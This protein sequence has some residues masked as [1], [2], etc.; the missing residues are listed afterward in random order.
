MTFKNM[1]KQNFKLRQICCFILLILFLLPASSYAAGT[2]SGKVFEDGGTTPIANVMVNFFLQVCGGP[3]PDGAFQT[4]GSGNY[5]GSLPAGNY[6]VM[7]YAGGIASPYY[8]DEWYDGASGKTDCN[9]G[10]V[11]ITVTDSLTTPNIN[12]TLTRGGKITGSVFQSDGTT[13]IANVGA[14]AFAGSACGGSYIGG[15]AS[16]TYSMIVPP[17]TYY[18]NTSFISPQPFVNEWWD[19]SVSS[20][21]YDC[22]K[23]AAVQVT[24][25]NETSG[26]DFH[27]QNGVTI[28]GTVYESDG[29]TPIP[30]IGVTLYGDQCHQNHQMGTMADQNGNYTF[31]ALPGTYYVLCDASN[32]TFVPE[33]YDR[34]A[35]TTDCKLASIVD[36]S[37]GNQAGIDFNLEPGAV[38]SGTVTQS[39]GTT[40]IANACVNANTGSACSG[41]WGG[42]GQADSNGNYSF[43]V[44]PGTYYFATGVSCSGTQSFVDEWWDG[45]ASNDTTDCN[46]A[47]A[48]T[49]T[50]GA[51]APIDFHLQDGVTISGTVYESDGTT[52]IPNIGVTLYG[53]KCH[54]NH[55]MGTM[56]D[57]NGN[58]TFTA[59]PGTYYVH[60][61]ASNSTFVPEWYDGSAGTTD[62]NL[63]SMLDVSSGTDRTDIDFYL[64]PGAVISGTVTQSDGTTPIVNACV[65]ANASP[66]C[67]YNS[68]GG[69]GTDA[70]GYYSMVVAPGTYYFNTHASCNSALP[71]VDEWWNGSVVND[72]L[73]CNYALPV[74][75]TQGA[76]N[77]PIDFRLNIGTLTSQIITADVSV[78]WTV[79]TESY[80]AGS[81]IV[82]TV[83]FS[84]P[85]WVS[86]TPQLI[87]T[88]NR[89]ART[90]KTTAAI[91]EYSGGSG[92]D[93]L[94]FLYKVAAGDEIATMKYADIQ[95]NGARIQDINGNDI[96]LKLASPAPTPSVVNVTSLTESGT[97]PV[98]SA[99][100]INVR[101]SDSVWVKGIPQLVLNTG[102]AVPKAAYYSSGSGTNILSFLYTV[103]AG[104]NISTLDYWSEWALELND[105]QIYSNQGMDADLDLPAPGASGS[106]GYNTALGVLGAYYPVYR[107]YSPVLSKYLFTID[108]NEK[109]YLIANAADVWQIEGSAY[110]AYLPSQYD[111]ASRQQ[112]NMLQAVYRFYSEA[113]QTHLFTIDENEKEYLITNAA[114][115]WRYE[116]PAFY[117]P[118]GNPEGTIPVYRFYSE[119]LMVHLFTAD[120][121]EM[122][123]LVETAEDVWRYEGVAYYAYP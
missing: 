39:D 86:G 85:V 5:T 101:F 88:I 62:C 37:S 76:T 109:E 117:V 40:P 30:N 90:G 46:S 1:N 70:N 79:T 34:S 2:V 59:L 17:G 13:P 36:V 104:D 77:A 113:L 18:V 73:D 15:D 26:I 21:E 115:V 22:N 106:L 81:I 24:L 64:I 23:A 9:S 92:T 54:Q 120:E 71:F 29:A 123:H 12:F 122:N 118:A 82:I 51:N 111:G 28:S 60:C 102:G 84:E 8:V 19:G 66:A 14:S 58:Y 31:T 98:G 20:D 56:A 27:L 61:N 45:S 108:E 75:V 7:T 99:I 6:Y 68:A 42:G 55:Q 16:G 67:D 52:P 72:T 48:V 107:F 114:D 91:A 94:T 83:R 32:S 80:D 44:A 11:A 50:A 97:Y 69:S 96:I 3:V 33:W 65:N 110:Y 87:L 89:A 74:T 100:T 103:A 10:T 49:V 43:A 112:R 119:A 116:G 53:D 25:D 78:T 63:A 105:G 38:I 57:Q 93:A 121:N 35:G 95:L 47:L 41:S 4:D